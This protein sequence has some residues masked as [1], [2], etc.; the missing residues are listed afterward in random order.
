MGQL[1]GKQVKEKSLS[2][3]IKQDMSEEYLS[4]EQLAVLALKDQTHFVTLVS[5]YKRRLFDY[6]K[7][8]CRLSDDDVEDILQS[9]FIKIYYNLNDFDGDL[10]FSSWAYR[11]A[12]NEAVSFLRKKKKTTDIACDFIENLPHSSDLAE[13][14]D[15][16]LEQKNVLQ[17]LCLM[18]E[19]YREVLLLKYFEQK[20]YKEISDILRKPMGTVATLINR[21][22]K[23]FKDKYQTYAGKNRG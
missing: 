13:E 4:D 16:A 1:A 7:F 17:V 9:V 22:K 2:R 14:L 18:D 20:D 12:H 15:L 19:K 8:F 5:R 11:I 21:A 6:L 10:K 23:Q 3:R